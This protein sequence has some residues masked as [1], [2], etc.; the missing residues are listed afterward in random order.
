TEAYHKVQISY[1]CTSLFSTPFV[2]NYY[3]FWLFYLCV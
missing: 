2:L 1:R 3:T